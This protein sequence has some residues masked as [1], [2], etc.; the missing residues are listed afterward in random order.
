MF[1]QLIL[2]HRRLIWLGAILFL[3]IGILS[4][5]AFRLM[6]V[7]HSQRYQ[8]AE[9]R[10]LSV[11]YLPTFRGAI[12]DRKGR[13]IAQDVPSYAVAVRWDYI[14]GDIT[15]EQAVQDAR[16]SV[17][18]QRWLSL[19]PEERQDQIDA[20]LPPAKQE[21]ELFWNRVSDIGQISR[22]A[23]EERLQLIRSSVTNLAEVVWERQESAHQKRFGERVEFVARPIREQRT[24][25][26]IL[27]DVSDDIVFQ[28]KKLQDEI[29]NAIA[30]EY[31]RTREYPLRTQTV[32]L[33]GASFPTPIR[34][35]NNPVVELHSVGELLIGDVREDVWEEDISRMPFTTKRGVNLQG[36]RV[37]DE[38]GKRGIESELES[39]LRGYRGKVTLNKQGDEIK[40]VL[41]IG[42]LDVS[43]TL[44]IELQA[45]IEAILSQELAF[46]NVQPW[47]RNGLLPEGLPLR[48]AIVVLDAGTSEILAMTSSPALDDEVDIDGYPWLNR[49]AEG[50][51]P[52]GSILKPMVYTAAVAE[53]EVQTTE[54]IECTGHYFDGVKDAARC[55]IYRD[56][57]NFQTHSHLMG[58]EAIARSCNI[59]F[60]E[61][62]SRLGF[63]RLLDWY[64]RYGLGK[65]LHK[66]LTSTEPSNSIESFGH[67]PT[68]SDIAQ[69]KQRGAIA[70]ETVSIAI[71]QGAL[72]WTPLHAAAS[73]ATLARGGIWKTPSLLKND[74]VGT[75]LQLSKES[76]DIALL[77]LQDSI[78]KRHGTGSLL[79]HSASSEE[80]IFTIDG[81]KLW[82]KTGTAEAP[83]FYIE[84]FDNPIVGLDHS[85]FLVMAAPAEHDRPSIVVAVLVEN[86][87]SGGRVA[88]PIANQVLYALQREGYFN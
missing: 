21:L 10:L 15:Q 69:L 24:N 70:F 84:G 41:P 76:V 29:P 16:S 44:D 87:G 50:L 78:Q 22:V 8:K 11:Q 61:L 53:K 31:D 66:L 19:S 4:V 65:P 12:K 32:Q 72:T 17:G 60:Y 42:G 48:G 46:M 54:A 73:Y 36:Y 58:R 49:A 77:G 14:T 83:P 25:H 18:H 71:G 81:V 20:F 33:D 26:I 9:S 30:I 75:D 35:F 64:K 1:N 80:R 28:F 5:Q 55:W 63:E 23:L 68:D 2:F 59:Y 74:A 85:W 62:G 79:R 7:E 13:I 6:V 88:G 82:G 38:V 56:R 40:R 27:S 3:V 67:M 39:L 34:T 57:F 86:G 37:G 52:P 47:H 51:Y 43:I 45:R